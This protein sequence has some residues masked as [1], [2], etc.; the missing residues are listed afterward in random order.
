MKNTKKEVSKTIKT[1]IFDIGGVLEINKN[2][3]ILGKHR[4]TKGVHEYVSKQ[5]GISVDQYLDCI[6]TTY[7]NSITGK[8]TKKQTLDTLSKNLKTSKKNLQK[9]YKTAYKKNF[10]KNKWLYNFA[11]KL[12]KQGY[13]IAI[14]SDQWHIS[15][16]SIVDKKLIKKF[17]VSVISC[18]VGVR[19][20][21]LKIYK[22]VLKELKLP[23]KNCLFIDNQEWNLKPA[24]KIGI[25]TIL[26]K[27]NNQFLKE[28]KRF[29]VE[30]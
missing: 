8:I 3:S 9:I 10:N 21:S 29:D 6:D 16:D 2:S 14:L 1:I 27:N 13:K 12:K 7:A 28:L 19:K 26:F 30:I 24:K 23:S 22:I 20:P 18:E 15:K 17:D 25:N 4:H 11:F 5:L